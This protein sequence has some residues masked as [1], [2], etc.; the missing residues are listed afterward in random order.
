M[1]SSN[2]PKRKTAEYRKVSFASHYTGC[3]QT[4]TF[5]LPIWLFDETADSV[6]MMMKFLQ[7]LR[8]KGLFRPIGSEIESEDEKDE[9]NVEKI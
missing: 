8:C 7:A 6:R 2:L 1:Q 4:K 9:R 5:K 3:V